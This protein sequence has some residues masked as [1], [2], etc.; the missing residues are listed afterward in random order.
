MRTSA[1]FTERTRR[2]LV[3]SLRRLA[4]RRPP[5]YAAR[6]RFEVVLHERV[7][8]V[9]DDL[10]QIAGL[11]EQERQPD[12]GC[13]VALHRLLTDGCASPLY[14]GDV[15]TSELRATLYYVRSRLGAGPRERLS[16]LASDSGAARY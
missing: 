13:V 14:N 9:R 8:L 15:H 12:P 2:R 11:L 16:W 7:A 6:R 5:R 3:K 10:L 1:L 4:S